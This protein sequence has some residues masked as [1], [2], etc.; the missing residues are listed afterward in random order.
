[1]SISDATENAILNLIYSATTWANYANNATSSPQTNI[2]ISLH[3]ADPGDS[4]TAD[5]NETVYTNYA[6]LNVARSTGFTAAVNGS[7][8]PIANINFASNGDPVVTLTHFAT[9]KSNA[10]P[11][12]GAQTIL[13]SGTITPNLTV[14]TSSAPRLLAGSTISLV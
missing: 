6:R 13:F 1:M 8:S 4:G 3:T 9:A 2:G 5:T 12:F 10:S 11:P 14:P 7:I